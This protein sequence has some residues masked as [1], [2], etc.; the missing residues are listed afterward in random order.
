MEN[1]R[2][3]ELERQESEMDVSTYWFNDC[4][5]HDMPV[6]EMEAKTQAEI[7]SIPQKFE[8]KYASAMWAI[9]MW[10]SVTWE[11]MCCRTQYQF[12]LIFTLSPIIS[13]LTWL[14]ASFAKSVTDWLRRLGTI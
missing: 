11:I 3:D 13:G 7:D 1:S 14:G 12:L 8:F 10:V 5:S 9:V 6:K 4:A 2:N